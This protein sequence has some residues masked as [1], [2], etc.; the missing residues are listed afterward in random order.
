M[1]AGETGSGVPGVVFKIVRPRPGDGMLV[2]GLGDKNRGERAIGGISDAKPLWAAGEHGPLTLLLLVH[3]RQIGRLAGLQVLICTA[4]HG[5][6]PR[7]QLLVVGT[8]PWLV[9][10]EFSIQLPLVE[11]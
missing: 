1:T 3:R 8:V 6:Q 7:D 9:E 11:E 4:V 10:M 5:R 2:V